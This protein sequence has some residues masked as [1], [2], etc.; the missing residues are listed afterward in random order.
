MY[1]V[2]LEMQLHVVVLQQM[3][4]TNHLKRKYLQEVLLLTAGIAILFSSKV[5][6]AVRNFVFLQ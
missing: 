1:S 2:F 5:N 6:I 3:L 4:S